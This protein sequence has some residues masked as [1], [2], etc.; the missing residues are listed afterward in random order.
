MTNIT[1]FHFEQLQP[2]QFPLVKNFYKA[3]RYHNQVG[4]KDEVYILRDT[5]QGNKIVA[6]VRLVKSADFL[7]LRSMVVLPEQQKQGIGR[8]FLIQLRPVLMNRSCWCFPFEWLE[9]FYSSIGFELHSP[10]EA[11]TLIRNKFFQYSEQGRKILIM[12]D[13]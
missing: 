12:G 3:A 6:A 7:I 11:P 5:S 1:N 4:K 2:T 13:P 10:E 8:Y 9:S